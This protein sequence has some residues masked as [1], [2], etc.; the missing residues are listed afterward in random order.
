V[1]Y[2]VAMNAPA[3]MSRRNLNGLAKEAFLLKNFL[4]VFVGAAAAG[5]AHISAGRSP[6]VNRMW[7]GEVAAYPHIVI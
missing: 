7:S 4:P 1:A 2:S 6:H 5:G 3:Y